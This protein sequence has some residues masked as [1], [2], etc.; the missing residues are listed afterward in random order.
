M[1]AAASRRVAV[2]SSILRRHV[3][4]LANAR[5]VRQLGALFGGDNA[6]YEQT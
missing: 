5:G 3:V 6:C 2:D 1:A 4:R